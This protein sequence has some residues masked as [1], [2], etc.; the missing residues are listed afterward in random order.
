MRSIVRCFCHKPQVVLEV[1]MAYG[2]A[3][4]SI[5]A[6]LDEAGEGGKLISVDPNQNSD[7]KGIGIAN[8]RRTGVIDRHRLIEEP[9]FLALPA[10][11]KDEV[12]VDFAY[13]DGWHTFDYVLMDFSS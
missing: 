1:G 11:L 7:W 9:D 4:L 2:I 8:V 13:V 3:S 6:A 12:N 5:L 10:L